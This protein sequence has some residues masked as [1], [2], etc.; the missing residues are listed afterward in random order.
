M[1][2]LIS[3]GEVSG[4]MHAA[5]VIE[6]LNSRYGHAEIFGITGP[7][8]KRA[9][10]ETLIDMEQLNVM[11]VSDVL[12]ALPRIRRIRNDI[13]EWAGHNRPDI[14][15][16]V[17]FPGFHINLGARLRKLGIPVLQYIAP[18]LWAWGSWRVGRLKHSQDKLACIL[19]FEPKWFGARGIAACYAGNPSVAA[20]AKGWSGAEL[21]QRLGFA[22]D[23]PLLAILPGSRPSELA[24]HVP[25]L[26]ESWKMIQRQYPDACCVVPVAPGVDKALLESL[27]K[28]GAVPVNRMEDCFALRADAAIAVSGTATLELALWDVPTV[29]V[30]RTSPL[31]VFMAKKVVRVPFIGL[32]NILLNASVMPELIQEEA[33]AGNIVRTVLPL[34]QFGEEAALQRTM[35]AALRTMLGG[36]DPAA[37]VAAMSV[38]MAIGGDGKTPAA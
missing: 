19:P 14:A 16:L 8:M 1:R 13:L 9:G 18:K 15:I 32:A 26:T 38:Q 22:R 28:E 35:F 3:A 30:Y 11:G 23:K 29:L 20:C 6:S 10:C 2:I 4:D 21:R 7:S 33:T 24:H 12:R 5:A 27:I 34:L 37:A 31:T 17:D 25:L 36:D